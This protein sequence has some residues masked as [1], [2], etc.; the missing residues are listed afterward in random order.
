LSKLIYILLGVV[1]LI[2]IAEAVYYLK[3]QNVDIVNLIKNNSIK[4]NQPNDSDKN[5]EKSTA[6]RGTEGDAGNENHF[7]GPK[8]FEKATLVSVEGRLSSIGEN[9]LVIE[10]EGEE[11]VLNFDNISSVE[12][13]EFQD[14]EISFKNATLE[15]LKE[16]MIVAYSPQA[17]ILTINKTRVDI[18]GSNGI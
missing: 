11:Y 7:E 2:L 17:G 1:V 8:Y 6:G 12:I 14:G 10:R 18:P 9:E 5:L 3:L 16:G 13:V 15:D 4:L